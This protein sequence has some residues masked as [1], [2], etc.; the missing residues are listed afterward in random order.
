VG[1]SLAISITC[2]RSVCG[3]RRRSPASTDSGVPWRVHHRNEPPL[4]QARR[5]VEPLIELAVGPSDRRATRTLSVSNQPRRGVRRASGFHICRRRELPRLQLLAAID[6]QND[7]ERNI[8]SGTL[9]A[10]SALS[11]RAF[12]WAIVARDFG[13]AHSEDTGDVST[14]RASTRHQ[15]RPARPYSF[16]THRKPARERVGME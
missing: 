2:N 15:P 11:P 16:A 5:S 14:P 8:L 6:S 12:R 4:R 3:R 10:E 9:L 13:A 7:Q 1:T